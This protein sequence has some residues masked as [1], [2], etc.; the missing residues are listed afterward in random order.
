MCRFSAKTIEMTEGAAQ[1]SFS[2]RLLRA[3][4]TPMIAGQSQNEIK[5]MSSVTK[6]ENSLESILE[7]D[8]SPVQTKKFIDSNGDVSDFAG[9]GSGD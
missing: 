5:P 3:A 9:Y 8:S 2:F 1:N 6:A 4:Q 7:L